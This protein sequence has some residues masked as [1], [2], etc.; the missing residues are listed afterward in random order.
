[1]SDQRRIAV[2]DFRLTIR[3]ASGAE[4]PV[5]SS[6]DA[7]VLPEA[8]VRILLDPD[9]AADRSGLTTGDLKQEEFRIKSIG[10][11][12]VILARDLRR[13]RGDKNSLVTAWAFSH[14]L[15]RHVGVRWLWPGELGTV[16]P[17]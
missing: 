1:M 8:I 13:G 2:D 11:A 12:V 10:N 6:D 3:Q 14:L 4:I 5:V 7:A 15:D 16:V 9:A 17:R